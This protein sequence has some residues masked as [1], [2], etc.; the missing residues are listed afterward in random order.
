[1]RVSQWS[2]QSCDR[3]SAPDCGWVW[4]V[5]RLHPSHSACRAWSFS[6]E[7]SLHPSSRPVCFNLFYFFACC[8]PRTRL[9]HKGPH[10]ECALA[11]GSGAA[12][13]SGSGR[14]ERTSL[15]IASHPRR[16]VSGPARFVA[17][18]HMQNARLQ[19]P[20]PLR[21]TRASSS[22]PGFHSGRF[23][24]L[25]SQGGTGAFVKA[26]TPKIPRLGLDLDPGR[27]RLGDVT[28]R[29]R[30][31]T[32]PKPRARPPEKHRMQT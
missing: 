20:L 25:L 30:S 23:P 17:R 18:K 5:D 10:V 3:K 15:L 2:H 16:P 4:L 9:L 26:S 6:L 22:R 28:S 12:G 21:I 13:A 32:L 19:C 27:G 7:P 24:A 8:I 31:A 11:I 29:R 14:P 1:M